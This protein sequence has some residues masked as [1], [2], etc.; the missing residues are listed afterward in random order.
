M[1]PDIHWITPLFGFDADL[2]HIAVH[3]KARSKLQEMA[4]ELVG[5]D[6]LVAIYIPESTEDAYEPGGMRGRVM[7][8]VRLT[9][10]PPGRTIDDY[11]HTDIVD[12]SR[13]WPI[14]W[15]CTV[16]YAPNEADCPTLREHVETLFGPST[17]GGYV[18]RFQQQG[19]FRLE[20]DMQQRLNRD[21]N[22]FGRIG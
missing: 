22:Q 5:S 13:R 8:A 18:K 4:N 15:P 21:F 9:E 3:E 16:V 17:F 20:P 1:S 14:G 10:M 19:P 6:R 11:F 12:G 2:T 7:G